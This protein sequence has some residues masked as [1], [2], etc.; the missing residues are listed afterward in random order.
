M[1]L[2]NVGA[3]RT[4][5]DRVVFDLNDFDDASVGPLYLDVLRLSTSVLLAG[6][7]FKSTGAEAIALVEGMLAA[8]LKSGW[9]TSLSPPITS[10]TNYPPV[11]EPIADML[12]KAERRSQRDL[13]DG[14][15]PV[16]HGGRRRFV[17]GERYLDL[18]EQIE[19]ALPSLI[20]AYVTALGDRAPAH[21]ASFRLE[22]AALRVAG[23]GSLGMTRIAV[24]VSDREGKERLFEL[25]E[26]T[27]SSTGALIHPPVGRFATGSDRV[28]G[29]AR[30]LVLEPPRQLAPVDVGE[31]SFAARRLSPQEDKL[32]L[33]EL[34]TGPRLDGVVQTIGHVLGAAHARGAERRPRAPW[35]PETLASGID[36]A[37]EMAGIFE[38]VYLAYARQR[39]T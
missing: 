9:G 12:D 26:A 14:R 32:K 5:S 13:L 30:A 8:Y 11:P 17:R 39:S 15:A 16:G 18:P 36:H 24:L 38:A 23:L 29:A 2:E 35:P 10:D 3:Y 31:L 37:I 21:A 34:H 19:A 6:R 1:H 22:D 20:E 33:E 4:D 27:T 25:K 28:V 7:T